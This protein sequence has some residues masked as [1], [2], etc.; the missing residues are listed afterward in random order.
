MET[1][2]QECSFKERKRNWKD[3]KYSALYVIEKFL[4]GSLSQPKA[5]FFFKNMAAIGER[6]TKT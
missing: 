2:G 6:D 3:Q 1:L 4:T 5:L